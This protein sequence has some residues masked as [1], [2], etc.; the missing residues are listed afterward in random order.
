MNLE[1][2]YRLVFEPASPIVTKP[3]GGIDRRAVT[4]IRVIEI[5]NYHD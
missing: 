1:G 2:P 5:V 4:A 3:D